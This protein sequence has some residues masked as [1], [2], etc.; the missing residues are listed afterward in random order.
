MNTINQDLCYRFTIQ[1]ILAGFLNGLYF[2][3]ERIDYSH[4]ILS[5][6]FITDA[7]GFYKRNEPF[8]LF[9]T[10]WDQNSARF[11][12]PCLT[13]SS[14]FV[15]CPSFSVAFEQCCGCVSVKAGRHGGEVSE[16]REQ[17]GGPADDRRAE[18]D[19]G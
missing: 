10:K 5:R 2:S 14:R 6:V 9:M 4:A 7:F 18:R 3:I 11:H 19:G 16:P 15:L 12:N 17:A 8:K 1:L 13:S